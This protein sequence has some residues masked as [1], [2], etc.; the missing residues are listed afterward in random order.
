MIRGDSGADA[1]HGEVDA[2]APS[3][4]S[5]TAHDALEARVQ[6]LERTAI[7]MTNTIRTLAARVDLLDGGG[8]GADARPRDATVDD[9]YET[10]IRSSAERLNPRPG[11][12]VEA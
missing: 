8:H 2:S 3:A 9:L 11:D 7:A 1:P 12:Q 10:P 5:P 6:T 4:S